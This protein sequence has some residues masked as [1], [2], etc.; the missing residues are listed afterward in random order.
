MQD[1]KGKRA[2][3]T[4][5]SRGLGKAIAIALAKEG[6]DVAITGRNK[7]TLEDV[8]AEIEALG[9]KATYSIFNVAEKVEVKMQIQ[10]LIESFGAFDILI[11]NAG[12]AAFGSFVEMAEND[13]ED[14][15]RTNLF[16]PYYV[17]KAVVPSMIDLGSGDII[18][19]SS[20]AGLKGNAVTSVEIDLALTKDSVLILMHDKT[21]DRTTTGKGKPSD[22]T[23]AELK[24]FNL[25]DGLGS[26]TQMQVP[27]LEEVLNLTKGKI[28]I[29][30]DKGFD[31]IHLVYPLLK[32]R[33]M[34]DQILFKGNESYQDFNTK[35]GNIKNEIHYMPII[36]LNNTDNWTKINEYL[37][38]YF[39]IIRRKL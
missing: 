28:L 2:L 17:S 1:L 12:I 29:N 32:D 19:V 5:G 26:K 37:K 35:Y 34:L 20:T 36:Q 3:V 14:I 18:N 30:L 11:N 27:T 7:K 9:V 15:V 25:R 10:R 39:E 8:V 22:Y 13:W 33:K 24:S 16:G 6:V 4:G 31:Y 21:I 38:N 23:L